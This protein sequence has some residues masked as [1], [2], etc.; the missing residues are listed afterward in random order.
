VNALR[1]VGV[2]CSLLTL[3][4]VRRL[5]PLLAERSAAGRQVFGG[6]IQRRGG[7]MR[8]DAVAWA[9]GRAAHA[10]GV[11]IIQQC[12]VTGFRI[13]RGAVTGVETTRGPI[14]A[15]RVGIAVAGSSSLLASELGL[16][17]PITSMALQAMVSE[18]VKPVLDVVLD[19]ALY[20]SQTDRGELVFGGGTDVY[21]SYA[22]RSG[23][24]RVEDNVSALIDLFPAFGTL[25]FLRH[26]AGVVDLTPD[27]SPIIDAAPVAG[28]S[29]SCGW[30]TY[31][32]KAIPAGGVA[33]AHLMATG[34]AHPLAQPFA[35]DR[36][37][38]GALI[39]ESG[40]AG[41]DDREALL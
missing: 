22:Q 6:F 2:D 15:P 38:T 27:A 13:A 17:L 7:V 3:P 20:V 8:H 35:L 25:R 24:Q 4:E 32:F 9:Y 28:V 23:I 29:L 21:P 33:L 18:P 39:D 37:R 34:Q 16:T 36:F 41:M 26:W 31:G 19:G 1:H 11:D 14:L 5:L 12:E 10:L 30:G 40:S